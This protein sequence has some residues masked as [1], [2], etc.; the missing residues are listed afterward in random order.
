MMSVVMMLGGGRDVGADG[1]KY[2]VVCIP[3]GTLVMGH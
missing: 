1:K 3:E 2:I